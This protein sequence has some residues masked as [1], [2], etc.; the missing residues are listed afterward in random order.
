MKPRVFFLQKSFA[1]FQILR[2]LQSYIFLGKNA[3]AWSIRHSLRDRE[4]KSPPI[5]LYHGDI[6]VP[7]GADPDDVDGIFR[8]VDLYKS[9]DGGGRKEISKSTLVIIAVAVLFALY[10]LSAVIG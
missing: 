6:P 7:Y 10:Y 5:S 2:N 3:F 8:G 1:R 4:M 9:S